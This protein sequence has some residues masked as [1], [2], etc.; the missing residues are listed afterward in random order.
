MKFR[1]L[2]ALL[3][4]IILACCVGLAHSEEFVADFADKPG[5]NYGTMG[6]ET[7]VFALAGWGGKAL[8]DKTP[9]GRKMDF[10]PALAISIVTVFWHI[11]MYRQGPQELGRALQQDG[12][13]IGGA[14][15]PVIFNF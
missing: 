1:H 5:I 7:G 13:E 11:P 2:Q 3:T 8:F 12:F 14:W 9:E 10:V 15:M 6:I 4:A